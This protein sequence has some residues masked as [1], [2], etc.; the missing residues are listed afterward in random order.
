MPTVFSGF[1]I[2]TTWIVTGCNQQGNPKAAGAAAAA[3]ATG[4]DYMGSVHET[5]I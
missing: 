5:E 4:Q 1:F 3:A 2:I